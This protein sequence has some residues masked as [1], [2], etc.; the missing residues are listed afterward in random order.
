MPIK[1]IKEDKPSWKIKINLKKL[2]VILVDEI[3]SQT[4]HKINLRVIFLFILGLFGHKPSNLPQTPAQTRLL[5]TITYPI[6]LD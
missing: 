1:T 2:N 3:S 5:Q 6:T 4:G